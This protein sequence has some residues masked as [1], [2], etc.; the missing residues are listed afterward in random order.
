MTWQSGEYPHTVWPPLKTPHYTSLTEHRTGT[1]WALCS[2]FCV[3]VAVL[4]LY[5]GA[6]DDI[7]PVKPKQVMSISEGEICLRVS[8]CFIKH[9]PAKHLPVTV[10]IETSMRNRPA[11]NPTLQETQLPCY[12]KDRMRKQHQL[13]HKANYIQHLNMT[14]I[15]SGDTYNSRLCIANY[16]IVQSR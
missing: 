1:I 13:L 5:L 6:W 16:T 15:L 3:D 11:K 2:L 8:S 10:A 14:L 9:L 7:L 4:S 12:K